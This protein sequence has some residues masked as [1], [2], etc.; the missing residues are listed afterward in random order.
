MKLNILPS[1]SLFIFLF[2]A[3]VVCVPQSAHSQTRFLDNGV[4]LIAVD[5]SRG[6]AITYLSET[7]SRESVVNIYD[8]GR[9]IQ[10]SYYSGPSH[11]IPPG[12]IAATVLSLI[13]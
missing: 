13:C 10:Q 9:Y 11:F 8:P 3:I 4:I 12:S 1:L 6:G 2:V 7:G 5:A